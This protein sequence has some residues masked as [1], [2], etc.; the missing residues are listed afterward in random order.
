MNI[1]KEINLTSED[2]TK[3][4]RF[5][6]ESNADDEA[7]EKINQLNDLL[8]DVMWDLIRTKEQTENNPKANSSIDIRKELDEVFNTVDSLSNI[9]NDRE[10]LL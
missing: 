3:G 10:E 6:G 9:Y 2:L 1:K 8:N 5:H 4:I 7:C